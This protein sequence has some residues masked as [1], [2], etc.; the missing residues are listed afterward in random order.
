MPTGYTS[1]ITDTSTLEEFT[2]ACARGM[3]A[4]VTLRD[5][6]A[7]APLPDKFEPS[8]YYATWL[9]N[10]KRRWEELSAMS[11]ADVEREMLAKA[12][13]AEKRR[14]VYA[15][16]SEATRRRYERMLAMVREWEPPT[17]EHAGLKDF[18]IQQITESIRFDCHD[19]DFAERVYPSPA[20]MGE[21]WL[22]REIEKAH[23]DIGRAAA[24]HAKEVARCE[25]RTRWLNTLRASLR[26]IPDT[27]R[28]D[29]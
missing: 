18:M 1:R 11:P 17:A 21:E 28:T 14:A 10:A 12:E 27:E 20:G 15:K 24:E 26:S 16:D 25:A 7:N 8:S 9:E 6:P 3:G 19:G 2:L 29:K 23:E 22:R 13:E 5:E 4:L